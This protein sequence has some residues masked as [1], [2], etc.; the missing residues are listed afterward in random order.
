MAEEVFD[1]TSSSQDLRESTPPSAQIEL[2][3]GFGR[4]S[5]PVRGTVFLTPWRIAGAYAGTYAHTARAQPRLAGQET[6]VNSPDLVSVLLI[7]RGSVSRNTTVAFENT[8]LSMQDMD[9]LQAR[10]CKVQHEWHVTAG[11]DVMIGGVTYAGILINGQQPALKA[12]QTPGAFKPRRAP[13]G[14]PVMVA[15]HSWSFVLRSR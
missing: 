9:G 5:E 4:T 8:S 14:A 12:S 1:A 2:S 7:N 3:V 6:S 11:P 13:C 10:E 15:P